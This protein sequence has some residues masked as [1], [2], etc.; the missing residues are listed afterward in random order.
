[1]PITPVS[2]NISQVRFSHLM[3]LY[4]KNYFLL[5][6][7]LQQIAAD[8]A[9]GA[10]SDCC[11]KNLLR[12]EVLE[13]SPWTTTISFK[14]SSRELIKFSIDLVNIEIRIY[15]DTKQA[16]VFNAEKYL[17][18]AVKVI[19]STGNLKRD[20]HL[21]RFLYNVLRSSLINS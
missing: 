18:R 15:E 17:G 14:Y 3:G 2:S 9:N 20:W 19:R 7:V 16:C 13:I 11:R 21:N 8:K 5:K 6:L 1:M 10:N 12:H 4:E